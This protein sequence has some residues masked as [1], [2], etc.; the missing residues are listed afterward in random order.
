VVGAEERDLWRGNGGAS[1]CMV[2]APAPPS[3]PHN[4]WW[5]LPLPDD[6]V[7]SSPQRA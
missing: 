7:A 2:V 4:H 6:G 1:V 5:S 3:Q